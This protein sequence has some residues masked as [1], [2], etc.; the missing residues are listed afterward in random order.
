MKNAYLSRI[1]FIVLAALPVSAQ[2]ATNDLFNRPNSNSL[3]ADWVEQDGDAKIVNN[4]LEANSPF[5][6]GWCS[7]TAFSASY[8][9]VV[10]RA[11]WEMNGPGGDAI[12]VISGVDPSSW[13]GIEVRIADNDGDGAADRIFF[14]AAVNAGA[15]Y[16]AGSFVNMT[17]PMVS[18]EV[19]TWFSNGGDTVNVA[20]RDPVSQAIQSYS[21]SGILAG[22]PT[23]TGVGIAYRGNARIDDFRAWVGSPAGPSFTLTTI[24]P[25]NTFT[26]LVTEALPFAPIA[27]GYSTAGAGPIYTPIGVVGLTEPIGIAFEIPSDA[28][29]RLEIVFPPLGV[30]AGVPIHLQGLDI[31]AIAL[32]NY[33]TVT[34]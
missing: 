25:T 14:N 5:T 31:S 21:A 34:I 29:G 2:V 4:K 18:G 3:G 19:T 6:L 1:L 20:L 23:G 33:F 28:S 15:W 16:T 27:V 30:L 8:A 32:T 12:S 10:V 11:A 7:H 24:R 17:T 22:P 9:G 13:N 26:F